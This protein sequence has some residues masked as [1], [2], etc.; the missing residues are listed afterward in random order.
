MTDELLRWRAEFPALER[1]VY[2]VSHSLGAM[3]RRAYD[4]LRQYADLWVNKGINAWEDWLP[5]VDRAAE[6]IGR[7]INAPPG[8]MVMATNVSQIQSLVASCLDYKKERNKVVFTALNFPTVSYVWH[9]E[10]LRGAEVVVVPGGDGVHAPMAQLLEAIDERTLIVP[11]S[12]VLFRSAAIKD[13][14]AVVARA[15]SV[16]AMVLLDCY[17]STGTV[18]V[19]V[20]ALGVDFACGGSVKWLCGGPGA[21][22]LYV[23]PDRIAQFRPRNTGWFGHEKPFAFTMPDQ[24]YASGVWRFMAGTP[25]VAALY[26]A[27]AGAEIVG[28]IGVAQI[29]AK[30]LRQTANVIARCDRAGWRVNTPR[31]DAER[32]GSVCFD[33]D[34]SDRVA[35]ALNATGFLCDWRPQSGIRM[36]P[37]FYTTDEEVERFLDEVERLKGKG[38]Q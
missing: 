35:K 29:R 31:A 10:R 17:Q 25:A 27:R 14:A 36:S 37:H 15:K 38:A 11:I 12:H 34:G 1:S 30:S 24:Q 8:S 13:V 28:E 23:R 3:P 20:T 4:Y 22:Y 7:I 16:G 5:E 33:F 26:Q 6:R 32:G 2:M 18:P 21:A 19:D 9:E